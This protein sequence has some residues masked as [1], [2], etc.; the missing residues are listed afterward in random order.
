MAHHYIHVYM[1]ESEAWWRTR[2]GS[3]RRCSATPDGW[4]VHPWF[5]GHR[6]TACVDGARA[7]ASGCVT[8]HA[9]SASELP[10]LRTLR[11]IMVANDT[12]R[13]DLLELAP[14]VRGWALLGEVDKYVRVSRGRFQRVDFSPSAL[15][16]RLV[17]G[18]GETTAVAA[19]RPTPTGDDWMIVVKSVTFAHGREQVD[20]TFT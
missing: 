10:P 14:V 18:A 20:V 4:V 19:L 1:L 11:P 6:P 2:A 3:R 16:V 9:R 7:L 5:S 12:R 8:A 17:G 13:F 15:R